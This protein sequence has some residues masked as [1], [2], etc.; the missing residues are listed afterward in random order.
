MD[1][2]SPSPES[3]AGSPAAEGAPSTDAPT[4]GAGDGDATTEQPKRRTRL[5][6]RTRAKDDDYNFSDLRDPD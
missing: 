3:T 5:R 1:G 6:R 2:N 4:A